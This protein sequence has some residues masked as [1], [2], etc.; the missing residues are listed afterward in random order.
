MIEATDW[1]SDL[2]RYKFTHK[3][4]DR[5]S[6]Q[7]SLSRSRCKFQDKLSKQLDADSSLYDLAKEYRKVKRFAKEREALIAKY[8]PF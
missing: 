6:M 7:T 3:I 1:K 5:R 8:R 2:L 4:A